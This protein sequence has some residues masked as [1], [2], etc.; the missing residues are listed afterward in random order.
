MPLLVVHRE[1]RANNG[2]FGNENCVLQS[3]AI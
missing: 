3:L 2:V 1:I